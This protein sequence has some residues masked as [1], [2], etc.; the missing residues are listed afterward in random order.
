M[1]F[2]APVGLAAIGEAV[3]QRAG[4]INIGL[5]GTMLTAAYF[6]VVATEASGSPWV[7][8]ALG[9]FAAILVGGLQSLFTLRLAADQ[10]VVGTAINLLAIGLTDT[11]FRARYGATGRLISVPTV[12]HLIGDTDIVVVAVFALALGAALFM[13]KTK[14]GLVLRATGENPHAVAA[15]GFGVLKVRFLAGAFAS[16]MAGLGGA[17]LA[18]G[19]TGSFSSGMT[20]G[21]GFLAIALV[22]FGRWR[23]VWIVVVGLLFGFADRM[24]YVLKAKQIEV[25]GELLQAMP[26][27]LALVALVVAGKGTSMPASLAVPYRRER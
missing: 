4:V 22:T 19:V 27:L 1:K 12:P 7:G 17:Y 18:V 15:A 26:Y 6:S 16:A 25:P 24:Q 9:V 8:L 23:P 14:R 2:A 11:L 5:E 20:G 13:A 10:V 3:N 21:R